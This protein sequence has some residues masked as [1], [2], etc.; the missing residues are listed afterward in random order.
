[1]SA[2]AE[3][4]W[5]TLDAAQKH[6]RVLAVAGVLFA[7]D[8]VAVSM[9]TL[10]EALGVGVGSIY[11]QVGCKEDIVAALLL[12]HL[13]R[14]ADRIEAGLRLPDAWEGL[15]TVTYDLV[16][17]AAAD[18]VARELWALSSAHPAVAAERPRVSAALEALV[19]RAHEQ[20]AVRPEVTVDDLRLVLQTSKHV[21]LGADGARRL[22]ELALRGM[23]P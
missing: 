6:A 10:A 18:G 21:E 22:A 4:P 3:S 9:P 14:T 2:L 16:E 20:G 19:A 5:A 7:R 1:M 8:G 15:T 23:R 17:E 11:R 12:E 13:R